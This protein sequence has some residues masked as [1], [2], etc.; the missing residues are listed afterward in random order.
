MY[1]HHTW[2]THSTRPAEARHDWFV[3]DAEGQ[4]LGRLSTRI[5]QVLQG[6]HKAAYTPHTDTGDFVI[7]INASKV[8]LSG[9]KLDQKKYHHYSGYA[10]GL[11]STTA[12]QVL[13][14]AHPERVIEAA[15]QGMVPRNRLG[16][17]M[18]RKLKVYGGP[19]HPHAAQ[20]PAPFPEHI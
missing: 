17:A 12:R 1:E 15:V 19:D 9:R 18:L 13:T 14:S 2:T 16:R 6:K 7:V 3:V 8:L 20:T 11:R 10:G 4:T 5:S